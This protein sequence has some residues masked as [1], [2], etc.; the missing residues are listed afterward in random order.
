VSEEQKKD[1]KK[2]PEQNI[3]NNK[4]G[5]SDLPPIK[6][7]SPFQT[8]MVWV[9]VLVIIGISMQYLGELNTKK[10]VELT[11]TQFQTLISDSVQVVRDAEVVQQF[12]KP[13]KLTGEVIEQEALVAVVKG[14]VKVA[15][16]D[17]I[18]NIPYLDADMLAGWDQQGFTYEF[19][20]KEPTI[21]DYIWQ[22]FPY[23]IMIVFLWFIMS[24]AAGGQKGMFSFGKS[25][26]KLND[27]SKSKTTFDDVAGV[28]EAKEELNEVVDF[29]KNP[30]KYSRLGGKIPKGV[31]LLGPPGTGK[32][33]LAR[34]VAGEAQVPFFSMS[35]S[36]FVEMFVGVG[37]S[38]VRDLFDTAKKNAPCIIFIDE[39]DAVGRQRGAGVG[40]GNDER[41]QTLNQMLVEMDGFEENSGIILVAATNRPDVLDPALLRPGRFD[42]QVVVDAPDVKG[43][44][45]ILEVHTRKVPMSEDVDLNL[46]AKGTSGFVGADIANLVNEAALMAARFDQTKVTMLDFEE[47]RDKIVMG[48]ER[49]SKVLTDKDKKVVAY[50]EAGHA[51]CTLFCKHS[52]P[53]HKV[54]IVPRGQALGL[55]WSLPKEDI[56]HH[57]RSYVEDQICIY[58]GGRAAEE[59]IFGEYTNG[60][61]G[62]IRGATDL[63]RQ[64]ICDFGMSDEIGPISHGRGNDQVFLGREIANHRDFSEKTAETIDDVMKRVIVEQERRAVSLLEENR[65][66]LDLLANALIEHELLDRDEI[67]LV[68]RGETLDNAKKSRST[69]LYKKMREERVAQKLAEAT[70]SLNQNEESKEETSE[71]DTPSDD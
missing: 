33:L 1:T 54:T 58:M 50:H 42:R 48:T 56:L 37:A 68:L 4:G 10:A 69:E 32:T 7:N 40:G 65:E 34:A 5:P 62:D 67:D 24:R 22:F 27:A 61:S 57:T 30:G 52:N 17:F 38:R 16:N 18:V 15:S 44:E 71:G 64:M 20:E 53:L 8:L 26:A 12:G 31:L 28:I 3:K 14:D 39:I 46:I 49:A 55:T 9:A 2:A 63:A 60:A 21:M 11:Y 36:D 25:K 43:R 35:G 59:I 6:K 19:M 51:I 70:E 45:G 13:A 41:E 29:L 47:A 66:K 23:I